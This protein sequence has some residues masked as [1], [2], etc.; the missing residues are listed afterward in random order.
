[1]FSKKNGTKDI[2]FRQTRLI[3][4]TFGC[5]MEK[6]IA[7]K[8]VQ[9][10]SCALTSASE[11]CGFYIPVYHEVSNG[12]LFVRENSG[13][14]A[15]HRGHKGTPRESLTRSV[16]NIPQKHLKIA[17]DLLEKNVPTQNINLVLEGFE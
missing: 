15:T 16:S 17:L 13:R 3:C 8:N 10:E 9:C 6:S 11:K 14:C 12:R 4:R 5:V 1:M 2:S 7:T